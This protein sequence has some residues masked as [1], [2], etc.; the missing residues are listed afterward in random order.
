MRS[1]SGS[2][3]ETTWRITSWG[4]QAALLSV[5]PVPIWLEA[6][7][8]PGALL[9]MLMVTPAN[10]CFIAAAILLALRRQ[11]AAL[12]CAVIAVASMVACTYFI[13]ARQAELVRLPAG[14]L[15]PGYYVWL[16]AGILMSWT[17][18]SSRSAR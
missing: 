14:H 8:E 1:V 12:V 6:P 15:G 11:R 16:I 3:G 13:E 5:L 9:M 10:L 4:W 2:G 18:F 7:G 17:A